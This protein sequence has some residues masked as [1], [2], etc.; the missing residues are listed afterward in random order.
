M[1]MLIPMP[2]TMQDNGPSMIVEGSLVDKPNEPKM[3]WLF[4]PCTKMLRG[5]CGL[6]FTFNLI[7]PLLKSSLTY[8]SNLLSFT[9]F[10]SIDT[11]A[12][13]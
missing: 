7:I 4:K 3:S 5:S 13:H 8:H 11:I 2:T 9:S 12:D 1:M 6:A 10:I